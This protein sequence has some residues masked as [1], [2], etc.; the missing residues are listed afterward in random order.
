MLRCF[1]FVV[2]SLQSLLR[3][4]RSLFLY[5]GSA[6]PI[7]LSTRKVATASFMFS[8][9]CFFLFRSITVAW[10]FIDLGFGLG[11]FFR[12]YLGEVHDD[13]LRGYL[14]EEQDE[15]RPEARRE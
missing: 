6:S 11:C 14:G 10:C 4:C 5:R 13:S 3:V 1:D 2:E 8:F 9:V 7:R 15:A 12:G